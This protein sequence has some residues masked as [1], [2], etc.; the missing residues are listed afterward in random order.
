MSGNTRNQLLSLIAYEIQEI[1]S[2]FRGQL[3]VDALIPCVC[4][5]CSQG[6]PHFFAYG[7]LIRR[8]QKGKATIEC[9]KSFED[10]QVRDVLDGT[11]FNEIN[12]VK[13]KL[14]LTDNFN[15]AELEELLFE[16]RNS[17]EMREFGERLDLEAVGLKE[18]GK[19]QLI[20]RIIEYCDRREILA[21]LYRLA[22]SKRKG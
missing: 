9:N 18:M 10:V 14:Y 6:D 19:E 20:V 2:S 5:E 1:H 13:F 8:V 4:E 11:P 7:D 12:R 17:H 21:A 22:R 16:F 15:K 3:N